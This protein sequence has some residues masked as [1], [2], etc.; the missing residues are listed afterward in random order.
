MLVGLTLK[1]IIAAHP[2]AIELEAVE[3]TTSP[4]RTWRDGV[5]MLPAIR[6]GDR[7]L[8]GFTLGAEAIRTFLAENCAGS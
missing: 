6:C 1:K 3:V 8:A 7:I 2:G 5:R 4:A